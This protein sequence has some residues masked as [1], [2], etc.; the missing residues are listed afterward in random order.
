MKP[1]FNLRKQLEIY[2]FWILAI[3]SLSYGVFNIYPL[4]MGPNITIISPKDKEI[5]GSNTFVV[6]GKVSRVKNI[7]LQGRP[8]VIDK[9]GNFSEIVVMQDPSTKIIIVATDLYNK[10]TIKT[11]EVIQKK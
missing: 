5:I 11:L 3:I 6:S 9:E 2:F 4:I 1:I 10:T 7:I 8:I